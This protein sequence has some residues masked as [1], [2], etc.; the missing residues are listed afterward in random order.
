VTLAADF[1]ATVRMRLTPLPVLASPWAWAYQPR[2]RPAWQR[3]LV[4]LV[5][6]CCALP[7]RLGWPAQRLP[8]PAGLR[9]LLAAL[10]RADLVVAVAGGSLLAATP[11]TQP[12]GYFSWISTPLRLAQLMGRPTALLPATYGP[13]VSPRTRRIAL[14]IMRR[15]RLTAV[16]SAAQAW[17]FGP[18][19]GLLH[20]ADLAVALPLTAADQV[21]AAQVLRAAGLPP[22][23]RPVAVAVH[24]WRS[25]HGAFG[26]QARFEQLLR[27]LIDDLTSRGLTVLLVPQSS[28]P[29]PVA[30]DRHVLRRI[31]AAARFPMRLLQLDTLPD[32][33]TL[34]A[35]YARCGALLT[36]RLH[37]AIFAA[38]VGTPLLAFDYL[39]KQRDVLVQ[40]GLG[41]AIVDLE[42]VTL[43][44]LRDRLLAA[45]NRPLP[46]AAA[47]YLR[48]AREDWQTLIE[49]LRAA[50]G[51]APRED[52]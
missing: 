16:R 1:P 3:A 4:L 49:R 35:V 22:D 48:R 31:A 9:E 33:G 50:A 12:A 47:A 13:F 34:Q 43:P 42:Q 45:R 38:N 30:D 15:A 21:R 23:V 51:L 32:P 26:G 24:D 6:L 7:V 44:Q 8:L 5:L 14:R 10:R 27:S 52:V 39:G 2:T 36:S 11:Q 28:G 17:R 46:A 18:L 19:R 41:D 40:F 20:S 37:A 25:Q 29:L